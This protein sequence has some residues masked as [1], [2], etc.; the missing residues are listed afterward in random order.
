MIKRATMLI[1]ATALAASLVGATAVAGATDAVPSGQRT[2]G[3]S[4]VEPIYNAENAGEIGFISTPMNA[5]VEAGP[6]ATSPIYLPVYPTGSTVGA[7]ICPHVPVDTCPDHGPIIAGLA[8]T[9][10]PAVY[11]A[12]VIG[13]DHLTDFRGG[14]AFSV[15]LEP[16]VVLFTSKAAADEHLLTRSQIQ[17]AID[18]GDAIAIP[19]PPA[20]LH[21][22][23]VS[24]RVW[25]LAVPVR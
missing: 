13:H 9:A 22:E 14:A 18:R 10:M 5:P 3:R 15:Y 20:T 2:F 16:T 24:R 19:L 12:G 25:N 8:Q 4:V 6:H 7:V 23:Q 17:A 11:A 1:A 21:G